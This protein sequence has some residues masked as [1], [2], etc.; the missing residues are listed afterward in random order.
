MTQSVCFKVF[1]A[2]LSWCFRETFCA[3]VVHDREGFEG[4]CESAHSRNH[5]HKD[6]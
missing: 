3:A 6:F 4:S 5:R 1:R 2:L